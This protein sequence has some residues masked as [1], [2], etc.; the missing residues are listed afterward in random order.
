MIE[1][2]SVDLLLI[3]ESYAHDEHLPPLLYPEARSRLAW[4]MVEKNGWGSAV[5]SRSGSV[6][7]I[8]VAGFSGWVVGAKIKSASWQADH[9]DSI[10]VFSVH[11]PVFKGSY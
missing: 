9:C 1:D 4:A 3:Q 7:P 5:F 2:Y 6:K 11:A 8:A 10:L